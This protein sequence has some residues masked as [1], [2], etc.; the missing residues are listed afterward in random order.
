VQTERTPELI[1]KLTGETKALPPKVNE[2]RG[3]APGVGFRR[4]D[5]GCSS[6]RPRGQTMALEEEDRPEASAP[7]HD[8]GGQADA[9]STDH[10]NVGAERNRV[11]RAGIES[12]D[13]V[14]PDTG[15]PHGDPV[16]PTR[17]RSRW[18]AR[19]CRRPGFR[20][21]LSWRGDTFTESTPLMVDHLDRNHPPVARCRPRR[22]SHR[23]GPR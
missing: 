21:A 17:L 18:H 22:S 1:V 9:A 23:A 8:S 19:W 7:A 13:I 20:L 10:D 11:G 2:E 4:Q 3:V 16:H 6:G 12:A 14:L 5:A 15:L